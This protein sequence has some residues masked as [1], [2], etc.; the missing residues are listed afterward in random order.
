MIHALRKHF[1]GNIIGLVFKM[2]VSHA[3]PDLA[4]P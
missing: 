1:L 3:G 4:R 2:H